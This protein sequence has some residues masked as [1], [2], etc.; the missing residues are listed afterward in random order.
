M[1]R[2]QWSLW[3]VVLLLSIASCVLCILRYDGMKRPGLTLHDVV[4]ETCSTLNMQLVLHKWLCGCLSLPLYYRSNLQRAL[5]SSNINVVVLVRKLNRH[6]LKAP[7]HV[8][9][10]KKIRG[11]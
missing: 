10:A 11:V 8:K 1:S 9:Y 2:T 6:L 5:D 4:H 3:A 7:N